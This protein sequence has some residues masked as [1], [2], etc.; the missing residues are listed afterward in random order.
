MLSRR[1]WFHGF[2]ISYLRST[3]Q[4]EF[5]WEPCKDFAPQKHCEKL[6]SHCPR[7][8]STTVQIQ[9]KRTLA[10]VCPKTCSREV[11]SLSAS[12]CPKGRICRDKSKDCSTKYKKYCKRAKTV[13]LRQRVQKKLSA[14]CEKT[15]GLCSKSKHSASLQELV[16][17]G[18]QCFSNAHRKRGRN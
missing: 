15:C 2:F 11:P 17:K 9:I 10:K 4:I 3:P 5:Y 12:L 7:A 13:G 16:K 6:K 8:R 1:K 14:I 18:K